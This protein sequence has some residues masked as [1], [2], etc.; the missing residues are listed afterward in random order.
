MHYLLTSPSDL[1]FLINEW[2]HRTEN[3]QW[4][5]INS[6]LLILLILYSSHR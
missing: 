6:L 3:V 5:H 4:A 1:S 2:T